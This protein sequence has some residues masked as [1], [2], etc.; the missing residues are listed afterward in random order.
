MFLRRLRPALAAF[1]ALFAS[2]GA[3]SAQNVLRDAEIE[4]WL[5]DYTTPIFNAAHIDPNSVDLLIIGDDEINAFA[6]N[7]TMGVNTGLF[8]HA[9]TPNEIAGVLAHETGHMAGGHSERSE[10]AFSRASTPILLSL[11]LAAGAAA[12][13]APEAGIGLLGLGQNIAVSEALSYSRAQEASADQAAVTYLDATHQSTEGLI[14]FFSKLKTEQIVTAYQVSPFFQSHP[15]AADRIESLEQRAKASP[16]FDVKDSPAEIAR[17]HL[18]RG[19]IRGFL[20]EPAVTLRQYPLTDQSDEARY[21]RAVAY[22][23]N[24]DLDKGLS[25]IG[26]LL[27]EQPKNPYFYELKGQML[28]EFGHVAESV[29]PHRRSAEL[30]PT[31]ALL[32]INLG[33]ALAAMDD[34]ADMTEA[35]K[36]LKSALILEPDNAFGWFELSR[37]YGGLGQESLAN[38]ATAEARYYVGNKGEAAQFARRAQAGL[39]RNTPEWRRASDI[40]LAVGAETG[41]RARRRPSDDEAPAPPPKPD[42]GPEDVPDPTLL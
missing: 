31:K 6:S 38:L 21:A 11:L 24:A 2:V 18:I 8:T 29:A 14:D 1:A 16:Y 22:Y 19:K 41:G 33:R 32:K 37:A 35:V 17:L 10:E 30:A 42:K 15:L 27:N 5:R 3:A 4:Q 13:G 34:Q 20:Q 40:L 23:R 12:A 9:E 28:F 25:E 26:I 7:L 39:E 36:V